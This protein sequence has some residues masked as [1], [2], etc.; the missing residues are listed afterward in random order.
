MSALCG[1]NTGY[2]VYLEM[3]AV[4]TSPSTKAYIKFDLDSANWKSYNR[5]WNILASQIECDRDYHAPQVRLEWRKVNSNHGYYIFSNITV[6]ERKQL[7][8]RGLFI[9]QGC[10]QYF[11][12]NG[13][14]GTVETFNYNQPTEAYVGHLNGD[15]SICIRR[16]KGQCAIGWTPPKY[17]EEPYA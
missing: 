2:H 9:C 7:F 4:G 15:Y 10:L 14:Q 6:K 8:L 17:S 11:F 1:Y 3:G 5:R 12:G 13:G 16:E